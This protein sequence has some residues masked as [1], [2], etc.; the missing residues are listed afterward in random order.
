MQNILNQILKSEDIHKKW[1]NTLSYLEFVGARKIAK[2]LASDS[3]TLDELQHFCEEARHSFR[4]KKIGE[5]NFQSFPRTFTEDSLFGG[6]ACKD[7]FQTLDHKVNQSLQGHT[8]LNYLYV[9][10]LVELRA[11]DVYR[12]YNQLLVKENFN[13]NLKFLICEEELHLSETEQRLVKLDQEYSRRKMRLQNLETKL[14]QNYLD[15]IQ[16]ELVTYRQSESPFV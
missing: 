15:V 1:L 11:L 4:L 8:Q 12:Q 7:Y 2:T 14:F 5:K 3:M 9:T 16:S 6:K 13:F 10:L